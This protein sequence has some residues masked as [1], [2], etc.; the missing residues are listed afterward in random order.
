MTRVYAEKA[1]WKRVYQNLKSRG[2][3]LA[4]INEK[5]GTQFQRQLYQGYGMNMESFTRL[6]QLVDNPIPSIPN[7]FWKE[8]VVLEKDEKLAEMI[9]IILGDGSIARKVVLISIHSKATE[10]IEKVS[11]LVKSVFKYDPKFHKRK[12]KKIIEVKIHSVAIVESLVEMGLHIGD[13]V[14]NQ[15]TIPNWIKEN[16]H[17]FIA[18]IRG[19]I[20]TDGYIGKYKKRDKRYVWFQYHVGFSNYSMN[21]IEG[22]IEFCERFEIPFS[23]TQHRVIIGSRKGVFKILNLTR[24]FKLS[25]ANFDLKELENVI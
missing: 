25:K 6:Q 18:C 11:S 19:L 1:T 16:D 3:S 23:R 22:F 20:D 5:I 10:Y 24:P 8:H 9:G 2:L 7:P 15:V 13:K 21:L 17:L 4:K 12:K 14:K